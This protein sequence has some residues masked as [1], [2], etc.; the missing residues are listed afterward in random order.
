MPILQFDG[1]R[2]EAEQEDLT[3]GLT[4][5]FRLAPAF[6]PFL[7]ALLQYFDT[8]AR[9]EPPP[10]ESNEPNVSTLFEKRTADAFRC[11]GFEVSSLGQGTG[12]NADAL[13]LA[14]HERFAVIIDAKVRTN[15]YVLGTE[16]RKFL[17]YARNHG[18]ELQRQGIERV[19]FIVVGSSFKESDLKKLTDALADSPI[20]SVSLVTA[21][22]L[23]HMVE[24][25]IRNRSEY[26]LTELERE[27][28]GNK[29][30][31]D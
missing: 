31:A 9:G 21:P 29:I 16:D 2:L 30:I 6:H 3:A 8:L 11:L 15:G 7:P 23:M 18:A 24:E 14:R 26:S 19:Y 17:E 22:A 12:R 20:R 1:W 25:S 10:F 13:A 27:F 4:T 5:D 28:F